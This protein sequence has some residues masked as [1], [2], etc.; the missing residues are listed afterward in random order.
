MEENL[1]E[2]LAGSKKVISAYLEAR[3]KLL[4][5]TGIGKLSNALGVILGLLITA[6]LGF[7]MV[8]FLGFLLAFWLSEVTGSFAL[9]F[10]ITTAFFIFLFLIVLLF[11]KALVHRPL[12]NIVIRTLVD[13]M[14]EHDQ[15]REKE[16]K[17]RQK[18]KQKT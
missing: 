4:R 13:Q 6:I 15:E 16:K 12:A 8:L 18:H 17:E 5:L 2:Y 3:W 10:L 7:F 14:E 1:K 11:R 9:G